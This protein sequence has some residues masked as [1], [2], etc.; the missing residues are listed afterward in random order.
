MN[1]KNNEV[2]NRSIW[3]WNNGYP[4]LADETNKP[5][6]RLTFNDGI[7]DS[8]VYSTYLGVS[9]PPKD[10][11]LEP[12]DVFLAWVDKDGFVFRARGAVTADKTYY[13]EISVVGSHKNVV[14]FVDGKNIY[15]WLTTDDGILES[16]PES[17][18]PPEG[19]EFLG[20]YI[21]DSNEKVSTSTVFTSATTIVAK[22]AQIGQ[23]S[24]LSEVPKS[25]SSSV[26]QPKS[27][28]SVNLS[29]GSSAKP[30]SAKY[31]YTVNSKKDLPK[32]DD[33]AKE[34]FYHATEEDVVFYCDGKGWVE[35]GISNFVKRLPDIQYR[36][37][38]TGRNLQISG[39]PTGASVS[40]FNTLGKAVYVGKV[41]F[42]NM[43]VQIPQSGTYI[44]RVGKSISKIEIR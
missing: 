3:S 42:N 2:E 12:G 5:I 43:G 13:A 24:S 18:T 29:S 34:R 27:S 36:I 35:Y 10:P 32:C 33:S 6:Y 25:S 4:Y 26:E 8:Y 28:S 20:W 38:V 16:L 1:T 37:A 30:D 22:Y 11:E 44:V 40:V 39:A 15:S 19:Y 17:E 41:G 7:T 21:S 9:V 14:T 31:I 23:S